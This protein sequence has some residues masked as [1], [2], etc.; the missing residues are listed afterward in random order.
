[1]AQTIHFV[2]HGEVHNPEKILYG[3]QP[4]WRLSDRGKEMAAVIGQWSTKLDLGAIHASPLQ[5]AQE[6][7]A[8]IIAKHKLSLTTDKNLIEAS[9]VFEGKKFELGSGVLRHPASWRYLYNPWKPSWGEPYDQLISRML[10][11]LFAA[12]DAA[13][14]KDAICVSH[15]LPIWILRSAVEGRRLLHDPRK[16][17]CTLASVTSFELD[18]EGMI[19]SVSYSEPAKHLL[20]KK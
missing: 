2:R 10:K 16:R 5:R 15:Q 7:V 17:E 4:G 6:T 12:R 19:S 1:M 14:G 18:S 8:P 9:N 3:L 11:G 20:P 13:G